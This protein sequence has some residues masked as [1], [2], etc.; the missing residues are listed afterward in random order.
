MLAEDPAYI[1]LGAYLSRSIGGAMAIQYQDLTGSAL[2]RLFG[3]GKAVH[4]GEL[5]KDT[6]AGETPL[7]GR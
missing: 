3:C 5:F 6:W 1:A 4:R 2:S 7:K